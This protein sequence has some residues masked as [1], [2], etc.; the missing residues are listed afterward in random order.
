MDNKKDVI[1]QIV[2][3]I[4]ENCYTVEEAIEILNDTRKQ[5]YQQIVQS[6]Y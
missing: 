3:I 1:N 5:I 6:S 4:A 2:N